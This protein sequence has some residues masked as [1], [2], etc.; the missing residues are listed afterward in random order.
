MA[1]HKIKRGK[2]LSEQA[3]KLLCQ[4]IRTMQ[5]GDNRLPSEEELSREY[6]VSRAIIREACN[7][8]TAEGYVS[9][10]PGRGMLAHPSAFA[11][12]NRID[13]ISDFRRLL[14]QNFEHVTLEISRVGILQTP[15]MVGAHPWKYEDGEIFGMDWT[16]LANGKRVIHGSFELP[17]SVF[18]ALPPADFHVRDLPEFSRR[19]LKAP[20]SY[21]AMYIKCGFSPETAQMFG[22]EETRPL[23]CWDETLFDVEDHPIG[24]STF[25]LHPDEVVMSV[26]TKF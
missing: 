8:L 18:S 4:R 3:Y 2:T 15:R 19:Y 25:Y 7:Q 17:V 11:M 21:C 22:V 1:S 20:I 10:T 6:G 16:Y 24:Y 12:K 14:T 13:R 23:Q 5:P 26:L 9:K